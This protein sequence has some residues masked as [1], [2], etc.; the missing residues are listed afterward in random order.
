MWWELSAL[1]ELERSLG[2]G[3][4]TILCL[5]TFSVRPE[6]HNQV[7]EK[8]ETT[9]WKSLALLR[10]KSWENRITVVLTGGRDCAAQFSGTNKN[11]NCKQGWRQNDIFKT[12]L[13][14]NRDVVRTTTSKHMPYRY[15]YKC[16]RCIQ[17]KVLTEITGIT[18]S[19][20][21]KKCCPEREAE[22]PL[23]GIFLVLFWPMGTLLPLHFSCTFRWE[24][25]PIRVRVHSLFAPSYFFLPCSGSGSL[26][27]LYSTAENI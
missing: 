10:F 25:Q 7:N 24:V 13:I 23:T 20:S 6:N 5:C 8:R 2:S 16:T 27:R 26:P 4:S 18:A 19:P 12:T 9:R 15:V 17:S 21:L 22:N 1:T 3:L 11:T 14:V